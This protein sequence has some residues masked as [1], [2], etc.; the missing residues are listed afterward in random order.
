MHVLADF[1]FKD[2]YIEQHISWYPHEL[3]VRLI[4]NVA[5]L[6]ITLH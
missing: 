3:Q 5:T 2:I 1:F 6:Y 4:V